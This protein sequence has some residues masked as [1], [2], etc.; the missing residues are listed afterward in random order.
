MSSL[1]YRDV[2]NIREY[3]NYSLIIR[4]YILYFQLPSISNDTFDSTIRK[5]SFNIF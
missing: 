3:M 1:K 2:N 4:I 5:T